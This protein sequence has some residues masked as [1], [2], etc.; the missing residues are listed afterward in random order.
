MSGGVGVER[1]VEWS[2][3]AWA[4]MSGTEAARSTAVK[5]GGGAVEC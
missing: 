3:E 5:G 4:L 1:A 2:S